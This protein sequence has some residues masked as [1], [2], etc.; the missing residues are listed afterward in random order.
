VLLIEYVEACGDLGLAY[1]A[2]G[3]DQSER[4]AEDLHV[5][6]EHAR[7]VVKLLQ[8]IY[9]AAFTGRKL[10]SNRLSVEHLIRVLGK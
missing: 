3:L 5:S 1:G 9:L 10:L 7:S 2:Y 8:V 4:L 6:E